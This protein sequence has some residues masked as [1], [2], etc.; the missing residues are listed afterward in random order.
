MLLRMRT[1][2][3][4]LLLL[5]VA[6]L[7]Q[8]GPAPEGAA[9]PSAPAEHDEF[10]FPITFNGD[11]ITRADVLRAKGGFAGEEVLGRP[12]E[13]RNLRDQMLGDLLDARVAE[14][15]GI[16]IDDALLDQLI[17]RT[18]ERSGSEAKF[19]EELGQLGLTWEEW[20]EQRRRLIIGAHLDAMLERGMTPMQKV[21]PYELWPT[22]EEIETA[23]EREK[24]RT[25]GMARVRSIAVE[26]GPTKEQRRKLTTRSMME[27]GLPADWL[28][29]QLRE[30]AE[31]AVKDFQER[32]AGGASFSALAL[33][34]GLIQ[35]EAATPDWELLPP[36]REDEARRVA[37]LRTAEP[38]STSDPIWQPAA[39]SFVLVQLLERESAESTSIQDPDVY[40]KWR[41]RIHG[42]RAVQAA[43]RMRLA[44]LDSS[45]VRP[46]RV[47]EEL[48][49]GLIARL[50]Q[51]Q[52]ELR[53]LGLH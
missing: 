39:G 6:V 11:I 52:R 37:F 16:V 5:V 38:G 2:G 29:T 20:R 47:R 41:E 31:K 34:L 1:A 7:A 15:H 18:L 3:S 49:T 24:S 12:G 8:E 43:A 44:A 40:Q 50:E 45:V 17:Q 36:R 26:L 22:P 13:L 28:E 51:A 27:D 4:L 9:A 33:E 19:F 23:L 42:L 48:R 53:S 35:P 25:A 14:L 21:L 30:V 10:G 32:L 46:A